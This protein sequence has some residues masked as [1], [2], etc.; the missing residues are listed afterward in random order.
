MIVNAHKE[1]GVATMNTK[2]KIIASIIFSFV[3]TGCA[4]TDGFP[5]RAETA[6]VLVD[7]LETN[8]SISNVL[9]AYDNAPNQLAYRN[10]VI[11]ARL[12]A[13]D[14]RFSQFQKKMFSQRAILSVGGDTIKSVFDAAGALTTA[15]QTSQILSGLSGAFD[16]ADA[17]VDSNVYRSQTQI[18][19]MSM[20]RAERA[21]I[22][23]R[24]QDAQAQ[25][26]QTYPL[27]A[28]LADLEDYYAAG[29]IPSA[30]AAITANAG[31]QQASAEEQLEEKRSSN[32][33]IIGR[34]TS[35]SGIQPSIAK[36]TDAEIANLLAA[37]PATLPQ[38]VTDRLN[39][40][41]GISTF[42]GLSADRSRFALQQVLIGLSEQTDDKD[43]SL[44]AWLS[45]IETLAK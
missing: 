22:R 37:P 26:V 9:T 1:P 5:K 31:N 12:L 32:A 3:I 39:N 35:V 36:L 42:T 11:A 25:D 7:A 30:L 10:Q 14:I 4:S 15:G 45:Q 8:Y 44:D 17:S 6:D 21:K 33:L 29:S 24:I 43:K 20:M 28:A 27:T 16:A 13:T 38:E 2:N 34:A 23:L 41:F 40:V 18:A 19:V